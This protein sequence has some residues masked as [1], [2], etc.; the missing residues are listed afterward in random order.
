MSVVDKLL[1]LDRRQLAELPQDKMEV[2]SLSKK[3][4]EKFEITIQALDAET[5]S[6]IQKFAISFDKKGGLKDID[7]FKMQVQTIL[8]GVID[9]SFKNKELQAHFGVHNAEELIKK[10]F[11]AGEISDISGRIS[12]LSGFE[13]DQEEVDEEV[14]N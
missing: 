3:I 5:Y 2:K 11:L 7:T 8:H 13:R 4:G 9:P 10:M 6:N 14:K 12:D 1:K